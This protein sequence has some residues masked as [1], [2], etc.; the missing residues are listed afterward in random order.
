MHNPPL[1]FQVH[2][3][4]CSNA[5]AHAHARTNPFSSFTELL[6]LYLICVLLNMVIMMKGLSCTWFNLFLCLFTALLLSPS[7][8]SVCERATSC[9][10]M[11][12]CVCVCACD[13]SPCSDTLC[14]SGTFVIGE[15]RH[16]C[17]CHWGL[18]VARGRKMHAHLPKHTHTHTH[19]MQTTKDINNILPAS[20]LWGVQGIKYNM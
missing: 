6:F 15:I 3:E 10:L 1:I 16:G 17:W 5:G 18:T 9:V 20:G 11:S 4:I 19:S 7:G 8:V 12:V 2:G 13:S 14:Y